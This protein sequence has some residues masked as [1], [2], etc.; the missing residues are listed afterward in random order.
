MKA[1][2]VNLMEKETEDGIT[3]L[4]KRWSEGAPNALEELTDA[5]YPDLYSRAKFYLSRA[6]NDPPYSCTELVN[7]AFVKLIQERHRTWKNRSHFFGVAAL[8]FKHILIEYGESQKQLKR[9]G[10]Y[11]ITSLDQYEHPENLIQE[12]DNDLF[13]YLAAVDKLEQIDRD[14][15]MIILMIDLLGMTNQEVADIR[16]VSLSTIK[17]HVSFARAWLRDLLT[18]TMK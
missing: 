5:I 16:N 12:N 14:K 8:I 2:E 9:G 15:A 10:R 6:W 7:M 4:L 1:F 18:G 11:I 3:L 17:R 13:W